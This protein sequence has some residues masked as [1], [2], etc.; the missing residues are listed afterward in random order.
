MNQTSKM[1]TTSKMNRTRKMNS[2]SKMNTKYKNTHFTLIELLVVIAI[3]AILASML[4]PSLHKARKAAL[5]GACTS[6][7]S[8][9]AKA[10][11]AFLKI[12]NQQFPDKVISGYYWTSNW[13]GKKGSSFLLSSTKRPLNKY[14]APGISDGDELEALKC[15]TSSGIKRYHEYGTSYG[16]NSGFHN[17]SLGYKSGAAN[18]IYHGEVNNP[19]KMSMIQEHPVYWVTYND[20][21]DVNNAYHFD[22]AEKRY[23][24]AFVDGHVRS[25]MSVSKD[26]YT[27]QEYT[28]ENN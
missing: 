3:I 8:Q 7:L 18:T 14:L 5:L 24:M 9:S 6:N 19:S 12:N 13:L 11:H 1:N 23:S 16:A 2:T 20:A 21:N 28:L 15:P 10:S 27:T 25:K 22:Y 17:N 4:L 26:L